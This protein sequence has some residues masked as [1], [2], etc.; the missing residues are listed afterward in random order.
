MIGRRS[1]VKEIVCGA[2]L[3]VMGRRI[4]VAVR[5]KKG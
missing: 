2:C 1:W 3:D 5:M 4:N